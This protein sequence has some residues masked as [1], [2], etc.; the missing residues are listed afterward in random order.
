MTSRCQNINKT[1]NALL[2]LLQNDMLAILSRGEKM[3]N[4]SDTSSDSGSK[5]N[6]Q[7]R[8]SIERGF[9][10]VFIRSLGKSIK[11][12]LPVSQ[13]DFRQIARLRNQNISDLVFATKILHYHIVKPSVGYAAFVKIQKTELI[14]SCKAFLDK[15]KKLSA[16]FQNTGD[17]L[18]DFRQAFVDFEQ[19]IAANFAKTIE[20]FQQAIIKLNES[21]ASSAA[22]HNKELN[23][24]L[25]GIANQQSRVLKVALPQLDLATDLAKQQEN[26][27]RT[28]QPQFNFAQDI[29]R[30]ARL[31][32]SLKPLTT[33]Q[34][35]LDR[36]RT[37]W[38]KINQ[39][40]LKSYHYHY[41]IEPR[42]TAILQRYNWPMSLNLPASFV[43]QVVK[44][45]E[46][47]GRQDK[48]INAMFVEYFEN[49][50]WQALDMLLEE[51]E[52]NPLLRKR[53]LILKSCVD[54][55]RS[56]DRKTNVANAILPT[57]IAQ[58]DGLLGD[59]LENKGIP[60]GNRY[61]DSGNRIGKLTG[62]R[63]ID[64]EQI[65]D[66]IDNASKDILLDVLF[67]P[68]DRNNRS[69]THGFNRHK[70]IKGENTRYGRK[71][72]LI[73]AFILIDFLAGLK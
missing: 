59:Y 28:L 67:Q 5:H 32:T 35:A 31:N 64:P 72:Y 11:F 66:A 23:E 29:A 6:K 4:K 56:S 26:F 2:D 18:K 57:L 43:R 54:I 68:Y 3:K 55:L 47:K 30:A 45:D 42:A 19:S 34:H 24:A 14:Q 1:Q 53:M 50:N 41:R 70:I 62:M 60:H 51:W 22:F 25:K 46:A 21:V 17:F 58:I 40:L 63:D 16:H 69:R 7:S 15:D 13:K 27:I 37:V 39:Q 9:V 12:R 38:E 73:R 49:N 36:H 61:G 33:L 10:E 48:A 65:G 8:L 71:G 44:L 52:K 20:Q